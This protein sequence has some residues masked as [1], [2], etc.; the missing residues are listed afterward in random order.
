MFKRF[1]T[2]FGPFV[3]TDHILCNPEYSNRNTKKKEETFCRKIHS[4]FEVIMESLKKIFFIYFFFF[5]FPYY[6]RQSKVN[7]N[8][9]TKETVKTSQTFFKPGT[10]VV[11]QPILHLEKLHN[12]S[13]SC[14]SCFLI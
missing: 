7:T 4:P 11:T 13:F 12:P 3:F 10:L 1:F 9:V 6:G 5:L 2:G 8:F 14:F